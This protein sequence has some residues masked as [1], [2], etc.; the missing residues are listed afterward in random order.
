MSAFVYSLVSLSRCRHVDTCTRLDSFL[1]CRSLPSLVFVD[2]GLVHH[3][4]LVKLRSHPAV[5]TPLA[6]V[7]S[8]WC[9]YAAVFVL[10]VI[11]TSSA[12]PSSEDWR[13]PEA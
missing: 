10:F 13:D 11:S 2:V 7:V 6:R 3:A 4:G 9:R 5:L 8:P 1:V 12:R